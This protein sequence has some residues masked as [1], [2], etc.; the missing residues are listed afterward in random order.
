MRWIEYVGDTGVTIRLCVNRGKISFFVSHL[1]NPSEVMND[2]QVT[3]ATTNKKESISCQ[4]LFQKAE[5]QRQYDKR[6]VASD[7]ETIYLS[8]VG[9]EDSTEFHLRTIAGNVTLGKLI[10]YLGYVKPVA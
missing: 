2:I 1:P 7:T 8:M 10:M 5:Y 6:S 9:N 4:T 3:V